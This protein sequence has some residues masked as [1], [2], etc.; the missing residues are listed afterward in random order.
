MSQ[1]KKV[2][3]R[4]WL[5]QSRYWIL[6]M[7]VAALLVLLFGF[8]FDVMEFMGYFLGLYVLLA[9]VFLVGQLVGE[10]FRIKRLKHSTKSWQELLREEEFLTMSERW[11]M[12]SLAAQ[13]QELSKVE[14]KERQQHQEN[15]DYYTM[16]VHQI[17]SS[18]AASQLL[19][20]ALPTLPEKT[21]LEQELVR[22]TTYTD[23][24]LHYVRMETFHQ[25]LVL[26]SVS[27]DE[28]IKQVLK[29]YAT[30]FIYK[31]LQLSYTPLEKQIV[32]DSKWFGVIV[33]QIL[34]NAIKYTEK[35]GKIAI[36]QEGNYL[37]IQDTG[38]GIA[39]ED[40]RR[41]FERGFS[42]LNGRM[43]YHSTGL[44]LYLSHE[45]AKQLGITLEV[46]S[47]V[48]KGT[49]MKILLEQDTMEM[50]D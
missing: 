12:D 8:A 35:E 45:I 10:W 23:F 46:D 9:A 36:F 29:K 22:I 18:I 25:D 30:F 1:E 6:L 42:G 40:R 4:L 17:K 20:Q 31:K 34:S 19:I 41:I 24:V 37:C 16:W 32:T 49:T 3:I 21:P 28:I 14:L 48:G 2:F 47:E 7:I 44:G 11:L 43:D 5:R 26:K 27:V 50:K 39:P 38:I 15:L 33:E 13:S